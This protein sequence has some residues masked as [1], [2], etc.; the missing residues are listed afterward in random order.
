LQIFKSK[1]FDRFAR[2][3]DIDDEMLIEAVLRAENG[4]IDAD[5]GR[6]VMK[7]RVARSGQGRSKGYRTIIILRHLERA[8]FVYGFSKNDR[9]SLRQ[10][11]EESFKNM[12]GFLL[13][14]PDKTLVQLLNKGDFI[15]IKPLEGNGDV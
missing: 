10:D 12:S 3:N 9:D 4:L 8:F 7:Q 2:K 11:E 15:E 13:S 14:L 5:L 6:G 1:W